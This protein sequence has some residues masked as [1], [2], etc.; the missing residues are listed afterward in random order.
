MILSI[1]VYRKYIT[2]HTHTHKIMQRQRNITNNSKISLTQLNLANGS[3]S[4]AD[5]GDCVAAATL[6]WFDMARGFCVGRVF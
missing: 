3:A 4:N 1:R 6:R 5:A 2:Q